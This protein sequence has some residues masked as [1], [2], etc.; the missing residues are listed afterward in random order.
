M[1][2]LIKKLIVDQYYGTSS[3]M[4]YVVSIIIFNVIEICLEIG[5]YYILKLIGLL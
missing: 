2:L 5:I 4:T 1:V 3:P